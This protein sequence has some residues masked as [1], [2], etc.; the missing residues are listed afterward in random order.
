M[1]F[2]E[3]K[4]TYQVTNQ[5]NETKRNRSRKNINMLSFSC[6]WENDIR[7]HRSHI[8]RISNS[9][10]HM[11]RNAWIGIY[12]YDSITISFLRLRNIFAH[13]INPNI[14]Q[15]SKSIQGLFCNIQDRRMHYMSKVDSYSSLR[16][17]R[18]ATYIYSFSKRR[19]GI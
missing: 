8:Y 3:T 5:E 1:I 10:Q 15:P 13:K 12:F 16:N 9:W 11:H 17:I 2:I 6:L 4:Q 7:Q 18:I 14:R 19:N